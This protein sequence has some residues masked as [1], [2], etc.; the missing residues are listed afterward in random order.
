MG[1]I[2]IQSAGLK[3]CS[4]IDLRAGNVDN[5][6]MGMRGVKILALLVLCLYVGAVWH[7]FVP[8]SDGHD[9]DG[10]CSFCFLLTA[11][12]I[13]VAAVRLLLADGRII[14]AFFAPV[15]KPDYQPLIREL[16]RGPPQPAGVR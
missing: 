14:A 3:V 15:S 12:I 10:A 9:R 4:L 2:G 5:T 13:V 6:G 1:T 16:L 8:H 7:E 11:S